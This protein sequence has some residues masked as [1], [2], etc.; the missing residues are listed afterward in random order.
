MSDFFNGQKIIQKHINLNG[1]ANTV[2]LLKP[3]LN[4]QKYPT[5]TQ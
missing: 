2:C 5:L 1:I 4:D 3:L